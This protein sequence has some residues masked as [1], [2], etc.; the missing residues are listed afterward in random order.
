M[1]SQRHS[2]EY[3]RFLRLL[4]VLQLLQLPSWVM[5]PQRSKGKERIILAAGDDL[6]ENR[7]AQP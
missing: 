5:T 6:R 3:R 2:H 7:R 1:K 4:T